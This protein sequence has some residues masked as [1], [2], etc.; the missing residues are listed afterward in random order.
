AVDEQHGCRRLVDKTRRD[1]RHARTIGEEVVEC[2]GAVDRRPC[3]EQFEEVFARPERLPLPLGREVFVYRTTLHDRTLESRALHVR[4]P[5]RPMTAPG[6]AIDDDTLRIE[7]GA[8][9]DVIK[10]SGEFPHRFRYDDSER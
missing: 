8:S 4:E 9:D 6:T 5:R 1:E 10:D 3:F 2:G 7:F